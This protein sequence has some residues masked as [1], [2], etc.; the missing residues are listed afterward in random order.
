[1]EFENVFWSE[2]AFSREENRPHPPTILAIGDSWFW[3][4]F[5]GGSL[6]N[7]LGRLVQKNEHNILA[8]GRN[9][10]E[11]YQYAYGV[12]EQMIRGMLQRHGSV[13]MGVFISGGGNDFAGFNDLRPL[14]K[15]NCK[16]ETT[17]EGCFNKPPSGELYRLMEKISNSYI[18]LIGRVLALCQR[19]DL[20]I[21]IHNYDYAYPSGKGVFGQPS[22]WLKSALDDAKVPPTL[23]HSC[24][25]YILD[26]FTKTLKQIEDLNQGKVILVDSRNTLKNSDWANELHPTHDGFKKIAWERWFPVLRQSGLA[27]PD[28]NL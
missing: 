24:V 14:L 22:T 13:L 18:T 12:Y 17:P 27:H 4:P 21:Y 1:M 11:A 2:A 28:A 6:L 26:E 15:D 7:Q 25:I 9:G 8:V 5:P 19:P 16:D 23:Q 10:A 20:K 3:Y